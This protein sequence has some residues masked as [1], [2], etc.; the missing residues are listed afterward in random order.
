MAMLA[1]VTSSP[2]SAR[3]RP[4]VVRTTRSVRCPE[5][6]L[7]WPR[8]EVLELALK[9]HECAASARLVGGDVLTIIDYTLPSTARRL[10]VIDLSDRRVL[11]NELVAHG[12]GSGETYA[13]AFSTPLPRE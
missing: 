12:S 9:A 3:W 2:A 8:P 6:R 4:R 5:P 11:F 10:W 7:P 1:G 13:T